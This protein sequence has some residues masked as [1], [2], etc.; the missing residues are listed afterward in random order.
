MDDVI[1]PLVCLMA[2]FVTFKPRSNHWK[3]GEGRPPELE[4]VT[5]SGVLICVSMGSWSNVGDD[6]FTEKKKKQ[7]IRTT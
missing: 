5:L 2:C 3:T 6:G 4:Q 1:S 7:K